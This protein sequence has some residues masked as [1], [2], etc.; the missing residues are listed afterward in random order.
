MSLSYQNFKDG[1]DEDCP[2][3]G[4]YFNLSFKNDVNL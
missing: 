2:R 3:Y 1:S 4:K